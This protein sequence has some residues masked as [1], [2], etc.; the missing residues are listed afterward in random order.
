LAPDNHAKARRRTGIG[1]L[2][3]RNDPLGR[4]LGGWA[5]GRYKQITASTQVGS[6][7]PAV[8]VNGD[9]LGGPPM[10]VVRTLRQPLHDTR[11]IQDWLGHRSIQHTVR[12]TELAPNR[13]KD[14]WRGLT[15]YGKP[16]RGVRWHPLARRGPR[17]VHPP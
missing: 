10:P 4:G 12:F 3:Y 5:L 2:V 8:I 17:A 7:S 13:F 9:R 15:V 11:A 1:G 6:I 14:F 16:Q